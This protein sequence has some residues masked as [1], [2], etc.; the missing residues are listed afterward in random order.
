MR[1]ICRWRRVAGQAP[2][3]AQH[4]RPPLLY[5]ISMAAVLLSLAVVNFASQPDCTTATVRNLAPEGAILPTAEWGLGA[6]TGDYVYVAGMRGIDQATNTLVPITGFANDTFAVE[7]RVRKAYE[8][9]LLIAAD[10]G[11]GVADCVRLVV[12]VTDM[13]P[14]RAAANRV[15]RALWGDGPYCP[16]TIV[17]VDA[18]NQE[19]V[20]PQ[21]PLTG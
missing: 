21:Q 14:H 9:M 11:A 10:A 20:S 1:S 17:E 13:F 4:A 6:A 18:L 2:A 12:F 15:T 7:A 5:C 3:A 16:R 8:N 19:D